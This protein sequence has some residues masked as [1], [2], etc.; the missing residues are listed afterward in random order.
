MYILLRFLAGLTNLKDVDKSKFTD[1]LSEPDESSETDIDFVVTSSDQVK[2]L[3]TEADLPLDFNNLGLMDSV[4]EFYVTQSS[5]S[6]HNFLH[7]TFQEYLAAVHISK[8]QPAERLEHFDRHKEGKLRIVL[9]FLA[10]LTNLKDVDKFKFTELLN[11]PDEYSETDIDCYQA[12]WLYEAG[13]GDVIQAAFDD[14][15]IIEFVGDDSSDFSSLGYCIAESQCQWVLSVGREIR[16]EDV[17]AME[18]KING[19]QATCGSIVGVRGTWND[20]YYHNEG[21][22]A[23]L[24]V[25]NMIF[26]RLKYVFHLHEMAINLPAPC[27]E[28]TWPNLSQLRILFLEFSSSVK[29]SL[30]VLLLNLLLGSFSIIAVGNTNLVFEDCCAIAFRTTSLEQFTIDIDSSGIE[31]ITEALAANTSLERLKISTFC[32]Y[33]TAESKMFNTNM[34]FDVDFYFSVQG[35]YKLTR[36]KPFLKEKFIGEMKCNINGDEDALFLSDHQDMLELYNV[37]TMY[38]DGARYIACLPY[39]NSSQLCQLKTDDSSITDVGAKTFADALHQNSAL[40]ELF[41][42]NND[43]GDAG[44]EALAEAL[45]HNSTLQELYLACNSIGNAGAI[46]LAKALHHNSTLQRLML[47]GIGREGTHHIIEAL[48]VNRSAVKNGI[49]LSKQNCEKFAIQSE[50]YDTVKDRIKLS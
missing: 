6:S 5:V 10:G 38:D 40:T 20:E 16:E 17:E 2:I 12:D 42:S 26:T 21:L 27:N 19:R 34:N 25:L 4:Y 50:H 48:T 9:R 39:H 45:Y 18:E 23:S 31:R 37:G 15:E 47:H 43:I 3:F 44:A 24:E 8:M 28:I 14:T 33:G 7:L 35:L 41:I 13:R 11:E 22:S 30:D 1:L 32:I 29:L 46:A 49:A 36:D